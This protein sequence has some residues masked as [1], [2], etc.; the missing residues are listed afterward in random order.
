MKPDW[1]KDRAFVVRQLDNTGNLTTEAERMIGLTFEDI[2]NRIKKGLETLED[3]TDVVEI[4]DSSGNKVIDTIKI[5][6]LGGKAGQTLKYSAEKALEKA[7]RMKESVS[8]KTAEG[9][10]IEISPNDEVDSIIEKIQKLRESS[11]KSEPKV[12]QYKN[13]PKAWEAYEKHWQTI[14]NIDPNNVKALVGYFEKLYELQTTVFIE[15]KK[16]ADEIIKYLTKA[17]YKVDYRP[18]KMGQELFNDQEELAQWLIGDALST[19]KTDGILRVPNGIL[20]K[21]FTDGLNVR[22]GYGDQKVEA[23]EQPRKIIFAQN[24]QEILEILGLDPKQAIT[25]KDIVSAYRQFNIK[26]HPDKLVQN[27]KQEQRIGEALIK[28]VNAIYSSVLKKFD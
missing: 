2:R 1:E 24:E 3:T 21:R 19:L 12:D 4:M 22:I 5:N 16:Y 25:K 11:E 15:D 7:K 18:K 8:L 13:S 6:F 9:V 27:G 14:S 23:K 28:N 20:K 17:G 10:Q 26:Y